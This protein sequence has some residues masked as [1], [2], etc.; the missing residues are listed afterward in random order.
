[1]ASDT[2]LRGAPRM[3]LPFPSLL[4][5]MVKQKLYIY[6]FIYLSIRVCVCILIGIPMC[7]SVHAQGVSYS[8]SFSAF[9]PV[10]QEGNECAS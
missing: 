1:V 4:D 8:L 7:T 5:Q 9:L 2:S 6:I 3:G 10:L